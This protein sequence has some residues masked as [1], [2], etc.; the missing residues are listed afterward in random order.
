MDTNGG[1]VN[2]NKMDNS[3]NNFNKMD[4]SINIFDRDTNL[5]DSI[6][7][8]EDSLLVNVDRGSVQFHKGDRA[9]AF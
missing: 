7:A 6:I 8:D 1:I 2:S 5:N 4:N 3:N 9:T